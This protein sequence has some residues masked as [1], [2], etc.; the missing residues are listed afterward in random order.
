MI[1][2][3][4]Q[5]DK[6][7][8][9]AAKNNKLKKVPFEL[10]GEDLTFWC[11]PTTIAELQSAQAATKKEG[12][13]LEVAVRMFVDK[14]LDE[15]GNRQYGVDAIPV[16]MK[17][18]SLDDATALIGA[19]NKKEETEEYDMKSLESAVKEAQSSKK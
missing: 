8:R 19:M 5:L 11:K 7:L 9:I 14:A 15:A 1:R 12:D 2:N 3:S 6:L 4:E 18:L 16:L 17:V 10:D 13:N